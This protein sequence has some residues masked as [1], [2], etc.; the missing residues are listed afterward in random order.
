[1][2]SIT[3]FIKMLKNAQKGSL[4]N[5]YKST[6]LLKYILKSCP[7]PVLYNVKAFLP[8]L[9]QHS[10]II[11]FKPNKLLWKLLL[12]KFIHLI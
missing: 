4:I 11:N 6:F 12:T 5:S 1:M 8:V 9:I 2:I 10:L 3:C 7:F